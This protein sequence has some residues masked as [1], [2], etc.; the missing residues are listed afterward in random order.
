MRGLA[1][2]PGFRGRGLLGRF[3]YCLPRSLVGHRDV[4]PPSMPAE[5]RETHHQNVLKLLRISMPEDDGF[6]LHAHSLTLSPEALQVQLAFAKEIE[7]MLAADGELGLIADWAASWS[8]CCSHRRSLAHGGVRRRAKP[9]ICDHSGT[10]D[11]ECHSHRQVPDP[12]RK[13]GLC[14]DECGPGHRAGQ[15]GLG[16][17]QGKGLDVLSERD[18]FEGTKGRFKRVDQL[19]P[20]LGLLV[21]HGYLRQ[22]VPAQRSGP[23]RRPS[24]SY[25]VNPL[26]RL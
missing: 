21:S 18:I 26:G 13:G 23:G 3:L 11:G 20:A 24:P 10:D 5:V 7:P 2:K 15:A 17:D 25:Q 6:Q 8:C 22:E 19:R 4:D 16:L 12:A 14:P 9:V 1:D